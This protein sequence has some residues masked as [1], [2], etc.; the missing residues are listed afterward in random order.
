M[1]HLIRSE[2]LHSH[3]HCLIH[4]EPLVPSRGLAFT[5]IFLSNAVSNVFPRASLPLHAP[6]RGCLSLHL[7]L[8]NKRKG[9]Q[10][11]K[12]LR[13]SAGRD[14]S[15]TKFLRI[16]DGAS[17]YPGYEAGEWMRGCSGEF[18]ISPQP[19]QCSA[20]IARSIRRCHSSLLGTMHTLSHLIAK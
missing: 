15:I 6:M 18:V 13:L 2:G 3:P 16:K 9:P 5:E 14:I 8:G 19:F 17:S 1:S 10:S 4:T 20:L 12:A 11:P 7:A